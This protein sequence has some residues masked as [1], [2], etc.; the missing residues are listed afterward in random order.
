M[1]P[2]PVTLPNSHSEPSTADITQSFKQLLLTYGPG[3]MFDL[4]GRSHR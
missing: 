2:V 1:L 4:P 3:A